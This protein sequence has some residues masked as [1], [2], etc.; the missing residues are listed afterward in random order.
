MAE[1]QPHQV[2]YSEVANLLYIQPENLAYGDDQFHQAEYWHQESTSLVVLI[3]GGCWLN[4]FDLKHI[5]PLASD[6]AN[7]GIAVLSIEYRRIGDPGGGWPGTFDDIRQALGFASEMPFENLF[8]VG[9]SAG[10]HLALWS[11]AT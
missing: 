4:Q 6:I 7:Q 9:H 1:S 8:V 11:N 3:H 2:S 5:R 10:G